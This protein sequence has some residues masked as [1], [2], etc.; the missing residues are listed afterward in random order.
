MNLTSEQWKEFLKEHL[1]DLFWNEK[2]NVA[3]LASGDQTTN[4]KEECDWFIEF[5][6]GEVEIIKNKQKEY[7]YLSI[8]EVYE[9]LKEKLPD[10]KIKQADVYSLCKFGILKYSVIGKSFVISKTDLQE[11]I[12]KFL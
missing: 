6:N 3:F 11:F 7:P 1:N 5:K 2:E 8:R 10:R 4:R 12:K 9:I